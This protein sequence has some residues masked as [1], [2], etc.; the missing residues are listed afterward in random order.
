MNNGTKYIHSNNE[1]KDMEEFIGYNFSDKGMKM[2]NFD[3]KSIYIYLSNVS[4][5]EEI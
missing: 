4:S 3:E 2:I 1:F 5:V